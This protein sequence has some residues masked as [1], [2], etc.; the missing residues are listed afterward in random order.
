MIIKKW[1]KKIRD[2]FRGN[3][4]TPQP[5]PGPDPVPVPVTP[6]AGPVSNKFLWKPGSENDSKLVVLLPNRYRGK[7]NACHVAESGGALI[8]QG[9]FAGDTANGMRPHYRF[10][11]PGGHYGQNIQVIAVTTEGNIKWAIPDGAQRKEY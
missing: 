1:L 5:T 7:V 11:R 2:W 3:N 4:P 6:P 10:A 8:E 9:R